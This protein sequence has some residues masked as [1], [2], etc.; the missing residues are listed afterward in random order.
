MWSWEQISC[1]SCIMDKINSVTLANKI[2]TPMT[3]APFTHFGGGGLQ[4]PSALPCLRHCPCRLPI[5]K[6][7][8]E[9]SAE[10]SW[11]WLMCS[12]KPSKWSN[13]FCSFIPPALLIII[14]L[15]NQQ[16]MFQ[17]FRTVFLL[18]LRI[19]R[20]LMVKSRSVVI[21]WCLWCWKVLKSWNLLSSFEWE[22][23]QEDHESL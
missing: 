6:A 16:K 17:V 2:P 19:R 4:P 12:W 14:I 3:R 5:R 9:D 10:Q 22:S 13:N 21:F 18:K 8:P 23:W 1:V 7:W 15:I 11:I 20:S